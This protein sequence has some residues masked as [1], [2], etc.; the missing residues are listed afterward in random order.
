MSRQRATG[1]GLVDVRV[2][3]SKGERLVNVSGQ[4]KL[5]NGE[6]S[7]TLKRRLMQVRAS[8]W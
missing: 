3:E 8:G 6:F 7:T 5:S 4:A 2:E 1:L